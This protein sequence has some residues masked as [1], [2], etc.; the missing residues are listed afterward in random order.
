MYMNFTLRELELRPALTGDNLNLN[1]LCYVDDCVDRK[2]RQKT[3]EKHLQNLVKE[4]KKKGLR[5][6]FIENRMDV[7]QMHNRKIQN[8]NWRR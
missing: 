6:N 8:T 2:K 1:N 4:Y 3:T 5:I 7:S